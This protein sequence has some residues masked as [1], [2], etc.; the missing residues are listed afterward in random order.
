MD[1]LFIFLHFFLV[2]L[3]KKLIA[4]QQRYFT[5]VLFRSQFPKK[6][7]PKVKQRIKISTLLVSTW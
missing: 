7:K 5:I 1:A 2:F 4:L 3:K 6:K